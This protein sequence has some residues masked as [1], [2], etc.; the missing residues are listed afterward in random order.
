MD[1]QKRKIIQ[2][3]GKHYSVTER[4]AITGDVQKQLDKTV[5][6]GTLHR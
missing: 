4:H 2:K 6:M 1:K 5:C 3:K